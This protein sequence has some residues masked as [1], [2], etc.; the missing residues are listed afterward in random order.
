MIATHELTRQFG[1]RTV[2]DGV[3][4]TVASGQLCALLGPN[5]AG[6]TTTIRMLLGLIS[7]S[8]G[9]ATVGG[10]SIQGSPEHLAMLR[11]RTGL[12]TET[13]GFYD[14]LSAQDNLMLFG[15]LYRLDE[16]RLTGQIEHFLRRMD[17]WDRRHDAVATFSKGMKQRLAIVRAVFHEPE[18]ILFDEPTAGLD[19]ESAREVR[20][21][22]RSL[23]GAGRTLLVCTH[24]LAEA[25]ELADLV[26]VMRGR[27]LAFGPP[28]A[29]SGDTGSRRCRIRVDRD[30]AAAALLLANHPAT[31]EASQDGN[32]LHVRVAVPDRDLPL[33]V[34]ALVA[35]G[36]GVREARVVETSLEEIYLAAIGRDA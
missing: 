8:R 36:Y 4:L 7:P 23:K 27:L 24:N 13:P 12:L 3:T 10:L 15:R 2:V 20:D 26:A 11:G 19:P 22:I 6:K 29:L 30:S 33:L 35:G 32:S 1:S 18:V 31:S 9:A 16:R 5:G 17:L 14:R 34:A 25:A 21:L 28:G